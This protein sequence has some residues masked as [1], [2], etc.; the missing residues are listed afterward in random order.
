VQNGRGEKEDFFAKWTSISNAGQKNCGIF[1]SDSEPDKLVKCTT[2]I[3]INKYKQFIEDIGIEQNIF[4][5][6]VYDQKIFDDKT[7]TI[8]KRLDGDITDFYFKYLAQTVLD[9]LG[10]GEKEKKDI[11]FMFRCTLYK[12]MPSDEDILVN[13]VKD[14]EIFLYYNKHLLEEFSEIS[15]DKTKKPYDKFMFHGVEAEYK[16]KYPN[17]IKFDRI[18]EKLSGSTVTVPMY[19]SFKERLSAL[20]KLVR[21]YI[22]IGL[23]KLQYKLLL[24]GYYYNDPKL[25]N[26]GYILYDTP[27]DNTIYIPFLKKHM[28][29]YILDWD[30]GLWKEK[31]EDYKSC[32][33]RIHSDYIKNYAYSVNGQY[34]FNYLND[35]IYIKSNIFHISDDIYTILTTPEI[36]NINVTIPNNIVP[37]EKDINYYRNFF[38][39]LGLTLPADDEINALFNYT[40]K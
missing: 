11:L 6:T 1:I 30:S 19:I 21:P 29:F 37:F 12:T 14:I 35:I 7:Y 26:Y 31:K 39:S 40:G 22:S 17:L 10:F 5:P 16:N 18:N 20:I 9:E 32:I 23:A 3:G 27:N 2:D 28:Q 4:F 34:N 8:M 38:S 24:K 13:H 15:N 25:D 36:I 33:N